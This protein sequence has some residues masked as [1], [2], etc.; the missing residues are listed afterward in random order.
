MLAAPIVPARGNHEACG[1]WGFGDGYF[2]LF[3]P[4]DVADC[5]GASDP[6]PPQAF[7]VAPGGLGP[8]AE[9]AHRF[10]VLDTNDDDARGLTESYRAAMALTRASGRAG[11]R[12]VGHPRAG[13]RARRLRRL[14][15]RERAHRRPGA[16]GRSRRGGDGG[17]LGAGSA[18]R[19]AAGRARC[20]SATS[21]STRA[22][23]S[24]G[25]DGAWALPR[26]VVVGHGGTRIDLASPAPAGAA[27]CR[28][29]FAGLA[30]A[31]RPAPVAVV[32][33]QTLHG[34]VLWTRSAATRAPAGWTAR[35]LWAGGAPLARDG[36]VPPDCDP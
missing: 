3:G 10:V 24:A 4:G 14:R 32:E 16:A 7:D 35:H 22:W 36:G 2:Q 23:S 30:A 26:H 34:L 8:R 9:A 20:C 1:A 5:A 15:R 33:T 11:E 31:G 17:D 25:P 19:A 13:D 27:R 29:G 28:F 6:M 21:T 12:L 18:A